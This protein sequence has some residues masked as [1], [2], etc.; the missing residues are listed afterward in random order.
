MLEER[1]KEL[2]F[3][4]DRAIKLKEWQEAADELRALMQLIP[5]RADSRNRD[6]ERRLLDVENRLRKK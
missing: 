4:A 1:Y 2:N 3:S 5:D 6:A